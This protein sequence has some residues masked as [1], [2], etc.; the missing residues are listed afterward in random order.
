METNVL[1]LLSHDHP[2]KNDRYINDKSQSTSELIIFE[3]LYLFHA[4]AVF[5]DGILIKVRIFRFS[6]LNTLERWI[7]S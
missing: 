1:S 2:R 7:P 5:C 3:F 6:V 4:K